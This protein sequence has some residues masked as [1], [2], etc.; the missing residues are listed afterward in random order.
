MPT[1]KIKEFR[2]DEEGGNMKTLSLDVKLDDLNLNEE[3]SKKS[4]AEAMR[5]AIEGIILSYANG[6]R[7]L[8][9][10]ERRKFYKMLDTFDA[11]DAGALEVELEDDHVGFLRKCK[12]EAALMPN[13]LLRRVEILIDEIKDR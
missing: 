2:L 9:E 3:D 10:D 1:N 13:K 11:L 6:K 12:K 4:K 7:G 8:G 5:A